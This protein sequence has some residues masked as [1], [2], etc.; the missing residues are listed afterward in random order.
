VRLII[1]IF[2]LLVTAVTAAPAEYSAL[3]GRTGEKWTPQSR[4]PD[5]SFAGYHCARNRCR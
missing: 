5:F 1:F 3:W 4:L 2:S